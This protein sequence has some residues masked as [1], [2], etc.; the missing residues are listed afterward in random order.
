MFAS[1]YRWSRSLCWAVAALVACA[2]AAPQRSAPTASTGAD[3]A[4]A[5]SE[6]GTALVVD[7]VGRFDPEAMS[8]Y[9]LERFDGAIADLEP[10]RFARW[11]AASAP[12]EREL[13]ERLRLETDPAVAA[14]LESLLWYVRIHTDR[15]QVNEAVEAPVDD[16]AAIVLAGLEPV[17][18]PGA[19]VTRRPHGQERLRAY[20]GEG[21]RPSLVASARSRARVTLARPG[22][23]PPLRAAVERVIRNT[24]VVVGALTDLAASQRSPELS[25]TMARLATELADYASFLREEVLPRSR[26][27]FHRPPEAYR[28]ALREAGIDAPPLEIAARARRELAQLQQEMQVL[29]HGIATRRGLASHDYRDVLRALKAPSGKSRSED[30]LLDLY[31]QRVQALVEIV[32]REKL[33]TVPDR[34]LSFR[35]AS[36]AESARL[37][38]P[39]YNPPRLVGNGGE[40]GELVLPRGNAADFDSDASSWWLAA[41]EGRPGH[42]LQYTR[43][44]D[45]R[46]SLA[47]VAFAFNSAAA[48]GWGLYAEQLVRPYLPEEAQLAT[49]QARLMRAA[50]AQL[51][52]ELNLGL[53]SATEA[54]RVIVQDAAF[55]EAWAD[56]CVD[57]YTIVWPGQAPSYAY[58]Y[59]QLAALHAEVQQGQGSAFD[60]AAFHDFVLAQGFLPLATLRRTTLRHFSPQD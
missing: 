18:G 13:R 29:A 38:A 5:R 25:R 16:P 45:T 8:A 59:W 43:M 35:V 53:T 40:R 14:D 10:G 50:H 20:L 24:P 41:H 19:S 7:L 34:A 27:D 30:E 21:D 1:P 58:G 60:P 17:L 11:G 23:V 36:A 48:E 3:S 49:L 12:V 37:P 56:Q 28:L 15:E 9:G 6:E 33:L 39:F 55:S 51:D 2:P 32:R 42:D 57:R 22:P 31:R 46:V 26:T 52:I 54:K 44:L 4:H 47:R